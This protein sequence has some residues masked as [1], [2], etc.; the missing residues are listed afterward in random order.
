MIPLLTS[1]SHS[2][3]DCPQP[4]VFK[5]TCRIC[6]KEGHPAAECPERPPLV[7]HNCKTEGQC[8]YLPTRLNDLTNIVSTIGHHAR[9]C[10]EPRKFDL[11]SVPDKLPEDAWAAMKAASDA[12]DIAEFREVSLNLQ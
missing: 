7:C 5:G 2:K 1:N 6:E 11:A 10:K 4:R 3:A 12:K 9:D 8:P